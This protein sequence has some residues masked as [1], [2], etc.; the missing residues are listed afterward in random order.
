MVYSLDSVV[1]E[2]EVSVLP[3]GN[4]LNRTRPY[5]RTSEETMDKSRDNLSSGKS[6]NE[7]YD[8]TLEE[9]GEPLKSASQSQQPRDKKQVEN[10]EGLLNFKKKQNKIDAEKEQ[11]DKKMKSMKCSIKFKKLI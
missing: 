10:C 1:K 5:I 2:E 9:P 11:T 6:V 4:A 7:V 3:H 8:L